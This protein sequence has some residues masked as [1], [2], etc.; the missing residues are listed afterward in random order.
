MRWQRLSMPLTAIAGQRNSPAQLS[1]KQNNVLL[2]ANAGG[3]IANSLKCGIPFAI[4]G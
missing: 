4:W 3:L 1:I 2:L